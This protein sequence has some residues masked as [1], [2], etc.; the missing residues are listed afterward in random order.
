VTQPNKMLNS[1][2]PNTM[3]RKLDFSPYL[4]AKYKMFREHP[5]HNLQTA[6]VVLGDRTMRDGVGTGRTE[7]D[8]IWRRSEK[9]QI[10]FVLVNA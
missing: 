2:I 4:A 5:A 3:S 6:T 9:V 10:V 8:G 1:K 7:N